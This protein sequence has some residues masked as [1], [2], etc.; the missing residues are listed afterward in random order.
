LC[1]VESS[2]PIPNLFKK[3]AREWLTNGYQGFRQMLDALAIRLT[4]SPI[5][6]EA[7]QT[8]AV[9]PSQAAAAIER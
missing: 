5:A 9:D 6:P 1:L 3:S 2:R 8:A 4:E 7:E